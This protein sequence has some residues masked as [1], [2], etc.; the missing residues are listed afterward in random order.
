LL[1][2]PRQLPPDIADF[3]GRDDAM[4]LLRDQPWAASGSQDGPGPVPIA[5]VT[6]PGG[7]G[8]TTLAVHAAHA[9]LDRYPDCQLYANLHGQRECPLEPGEIL[10]EF[11]RALGA[12][13]PAGGGI[14]ERAALLRTLLA[15]RRALV[16]LDDAHDSAQVR[17]LLPGSPTCA[18]LVTSRS[19]LADLEGALSVDLDLLAPREALA[20]LGRIAGGDRVAADP[21]GAR[22]VID[23]C[24]HL[25]LAIRIAGARLAGRPGWPVQALA[26]QLATA[27]HRLDVLEYGDR[28]VRTSFQVSYRALGERP[29]LGLEGRR[30]FRLVGLLDGPDLGLGTAAALLDRPPDQAERLLE[31]LVDVRLLDSPRPHRYRQHDLVRLFAR[32]LAHVEDSPA[33]RHAAVERALRFTLASI[34]RADLR[35]RPGRLVPYMDPRGGPAGLPALDHAEALEWLETEHLN[36]RALAFQAASDPSVPVELTARLV[37]HLCGF[38]EVRGPWT[39]WERLA[40]AVLA[41]ARRDGDRHAEALAVQELGLLASRRGLLDEASAHSRRSLALH[42]DAGDRAGEARAHNVLGSIA[43]HRGETEAAAQHFQT[44]LELCRRHG[45]RRGE[46][47]ILTNLGIVNQLRGELD[48]AT[49]CYEESLAIHREIGNPDGEANT[50]SNLGCLFQERG[51]NDRAMACQEEALRLYQASANRYCEVETLVELAR[52]CRAAGRLREAAGHAGAALA[53]AREM[54][55]AVQEAEAL[56]ELGHARWDAGRHRPARECWLAALAILERLDGDG[57]SALRELLSSP[58]PSARERVRRQD[59]AGILSHRELEV[60]GLVSQGLS[61][62]E[63]AGRLGLR[64][65][66]VASHVVH[67]LNKLDFSSRT[68]IAAWVAERRLD[69]APTPDGMRSDLAPIV[70]SSQVLGQGREALAQ[71]AGRAAEPEAH[72]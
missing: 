3:T 25:P 61:N 13:V 55:D 4:A 39:D 6:G 44:A 37:A 40:R 48:R 18:V 16:V 14:D 33:C 68:Q 20:L 66:T 22:Q 12:G 72:V 26:L 30:A 64:R 52:A 21:D 42:R 63:I 67:I 31:L 46:C 32:E 34:E 59:G 62:P 47:G 1:G 29:G 65:P 49:A 38:I 15:G 54:K 45:I 2:R 8:K 35:V 53:L 5:V 11:L 56:R 58:A 19:A 41:A 69:E 50:L 28:G 9:L 70:T 36:V 23:A 27:R 10:A 57:A 43:L 24:G 71:D 7:I 51:R 60:A 17:P